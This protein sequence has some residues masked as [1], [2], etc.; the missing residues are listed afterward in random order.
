MINLIE[1]NTGPLFQQMKEQILNVIKESGLKPGD[2]ILSENQFCVASDVSI[3]TVRRALA[4]LEKDGVIV[5]RQGK[6]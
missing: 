4:E 2:K 1:K 6:G 5:R 3:R